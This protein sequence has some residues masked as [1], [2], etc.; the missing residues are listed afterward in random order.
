MTST[1]RRN[2]GGRYS[3]KTQSDWYK[4]IESENLARI[5]ADD[6]ERAAVTR[7]AQVVGDAVTAMPESASRIARA[8]NLV[9]AGQ[10]WPLTSGSYLVGSQSD[11]V[12][13]HLVHR[14]PWAC[15]CA[16]AKYRK[17]LCAHTLAV[18]LTVKIGT[19]YHANYTM[20]EAA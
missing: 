16:H 17:S 18:M 14:G 1:T 13:A 9:Q 3:T 10:V 12:L 6:T 5:E 8:A 11:T 7:L 19:N 20:P 4:A 2:E 15:D